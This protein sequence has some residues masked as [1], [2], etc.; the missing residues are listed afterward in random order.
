MGEEKVY[1]GLQAMRGMASML[2]LVMHSALYYAIRLSP[3]RFPWDWQR[4]ARG[5]DLFFVLSGFMMVYSSEKLFGN[6]NGWKL[7]AERRV[8][9]IVPIYWIATTIKLV[10]LLAAAGMLIHSQFDWGRAISSYF[11]IPYRSSEGIE[12]L[13]IVGW[14]LNFEMFFYAIFT[15]A[16]RLRANI[17]IF[18]AAIL[19]PLAIAS[20]F[21]QPDW[22]GASFYLNPIVLEFFFGMLIAKWV[23][24]GKRMH[25][26]IAAFMLVGGLV[27]LL[28]LPIPKPYILSVN[29]FAASAAIWGTAALEPRLKWLP[30]W[31]LYLGDISYVLYLFHP[32]IAPA[33]PYILKRMHMHNPLLSVVLSVTAAVA[34]ACLIHQYLERPITERLRKWTGQRR[35]VMADL[36]TR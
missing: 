17:Y 24:S 33:G 18:V 26:A 31:T 14:T 5:V 11:F 4:G 1:R 21:R 19:F 29:G 22:P 34:A 27:W 10:A 15:L 28:F 3:E 2:V 23:L 25:P 32:F 6:A 20:V 8:I 36:A 7:F 35:V 9:R 16:L 13:L 30:K 12:P